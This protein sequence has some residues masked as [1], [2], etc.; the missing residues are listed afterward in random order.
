M[1]AYIQTT[2]PMRHGARGNQ[3]N[4]N[5]Y[6]HAMSCEECAAWQQNRLVLLC[7]F[8]SP[9]RESFREHVQQLSKSRKAANPTSGPP[10]YENI[11]RDSRNPNFMEPPYFALGKLDDGAAFEPDKNCYERADF[12]IDNPAQFETIAPEAQK[13]KYQP[14]QF[15]YSDK[16]FYG[17]ILRRHG[18]YPSLKAF[19]LC[20][21]LLLPIK[22][23]E[24]NISRSPYLIGRFTACPY[25]FVCSYSPGESRPLRI[26][27]APQESP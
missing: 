18:A 25:S 11:W 12:H 8:A 4:A 7:L 26:R 16:Y 20:P 1:R 3:N 23:S 21:F 17:N 5:Y 27:S 6:A 15:E 19:Y 13:R 2:R 14:E 22:K 9:S 10:T 24:R